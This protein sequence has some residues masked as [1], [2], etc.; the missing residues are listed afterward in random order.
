VSSNR[1]KRNLQAATP[2][3][4]QMKE[5]IKGLLAESERTASMTADEFFQDFRTKN[6]ERHFPEMI[7]STWLTSAESTA[8]ASWAKV[9]RNAD[10]ELA[11][12]VDAAHWEHALKRAYVAAE[13]EHGA[14]SQQ[15]T[16]PERYGQEILKGA[17]ETVGNSILGLIHYCPCYLFLSNGAEPF[18]I[19]EIEFIPGSSL[20]RRIKAA[21]GHELAWGEEYMR[22]AASSDSKLGESSISQDAWDVLQMSRFPWIAIVQTRGYPVRMAQQRANDAARLA[23]AGIGLKV[24]PRQSA[25]VSLVN[26]WGRPL[27]QRSMIQVPGRDIA[28]G[29]TNNRPQIDVDPTT[30]RGFFAGQTTYFE[31]LG[32]VIAE[33]FANEPPQGES[34]AGLTPPLIV[35]G[36]IRGAWLNALYWYH[37]GCL[38]TSDARAAICFASALESLSDGIGSPAIIKSVE[39][40]LGIDRCTVVVAESK[41]SLEEAIQHIYSF[42]RSQ[43]VHG[44]HFVLFTEYSDAR[45]IAS[46]LCRYSLISFQKNLKTYEERF[47]RATAADGKKAFLRW[48]MAQSNTD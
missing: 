24:S 47:K 20:G 28:T 33:A 36:E 8:L 9:V 30:L 13:L 27:Q 46:E 40:L 45:G 39:A 41:W 4:E 5:L 6:P 17:R 19:G 42:G 1:R 31:W 44:G 3:A 43:S 23:I 48:L 29:L 15:P 32:A 22:L 2:D 10:P 25:T 34:T 21:A 18:R 14:Q 38:E 7:D 16:T 12:T 26:E 35:L 37:T 11:R